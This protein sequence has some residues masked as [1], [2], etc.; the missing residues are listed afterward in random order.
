MFEIALQLIRTY[1]EVSS[2]L[3]MFLVILELT[4]NE[5]GAIRLYGFGFTAMRKRLGGL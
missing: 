2:G 1:T 3:E 5:G 4:F